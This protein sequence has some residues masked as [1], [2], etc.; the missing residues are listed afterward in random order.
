MLVGPVIEFRGE[1]GEVH[2]WHVDGIRT[3]T[4]IAGEVHIEIRGGDRSQPPIKLVVEDPGFERRVDDVRLSADPGAGKAFRIRWKRT[5]LLT[6]VGVAAVVLPLGYLLATRGAVYAH[7]FVP[8]EQERALGDLVYKRVMNDYEVCED[9]ALTDFLNHMVDELSEDGSPYDCDVTVVKSDDVNAFA[10]PGGRII[11]LSG[12]LDACP[13]PD[14]VAGVLAH[15]VVHVE[16]RHGL[17]QMMRSLGLL[18]FARQAIGAGFE[19]LETAE[20]VTEIMSLLS[21]L[22]YSREMEEEADRLAIVKLHRSRRTVEG[23]KEF[24]EWIRDEFGMEKLEHALSWLG[25]H[26]VTA[27]R[28]AV[29]EAAASAEEGSR[30][31]WLEE[32]KTWVRFQHTCPAHAD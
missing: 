5:T 8:V 9:A 15:E 27:D 16:Q 11:V 14:G 12:L 2:D 26:P 6:L 22:K 28:I 20:T 1:A 23:M 24:F 3:T 29:C 21:V 7:R 30:M 10:V 18:F 13:T 17:K 31:P 25:S 19:Q 32:E 4:V